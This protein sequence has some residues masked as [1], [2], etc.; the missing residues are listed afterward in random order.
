MRIRLP[1]FRLAMLAAVFAAVMAL[2]IGIFPATQAAHAEDNGVGL[3][4]LMGW[5]T[6]NYIGRDPT[7]ANVEAQAAALKSSGLL[8]AGYNYVNIDDFY[9]ECPGS[10]GPNVDAYGRWLTDPSKFPPSGSTPG[11]EVVA[12]YVHSLGEK[13]GFYVTPGISDQA[14]AENT[15][16]MGTSYTA[17]EIA[18]GVSEHNY[19]CGG[20]QGIDYSKPGAQAFI[21]SWADELASW[22][23]DYVKVD[24]V[25][26]G[27]IGDI[28]AWSAALAQTG[29]PIHLELSNNLAISDASTWAQYSNG[30]R[31]SGDIQCYCGSPF[32][33]VT[34]S[35][36]QSRFAQ[37]ANWAPYGGP[38]AFNDYDSI[39]L[40]DGPTDDGITAPE[41]QSMM[42]LWAMAASPLVIDA[43]LTHLNSTDLTYLKNSA[44]IGVD[45][46]SIDATRI[47]NS[48]NDQVFAKTESNGDIILGLFNY[49]GTASTTDTVSLS[50]AGLHGSGTATNLWTGASAGTVSGTY[51]VTL[52]AGA[53][54]LLKIVPKGS[55]TIQADSSGNTL[56]GATAVGSCS[57]CADG[58]KVRF[59][60]DGAANYI[61]INNIDEPSAGSYSL[62]VVYCLDG[63]RTFDISVNGGTGTAVALTGASWSEPASRTMTVTLNAG[64]NTIKFYNDSAYAPDL[65]EVTITG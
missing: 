15:P 42:S 20:M 52:G 60:G 28:Q 24:G 32:P 61:T 17:S 53:V 6:W 2:T 21:N 41:E 9:Y 37:V 7:A 47:V 49:S 31:T 48:G 26:T 50:S 58:E 10:Q 8:A 46:D 14:V 55:T 59:I 16:I 25:G 22:G 1:R 23:A 36:V 43:D 39:A 63:S 56:A 12:N 51:S 40:G 33:L 3:T 38:G 30:W 65:S 29:R 27:D 45:Q 35:G 5:S 44:V 18:N 57:G 64:E 11:L 62:T 13:I 4:P 54:Q 34:W 19:N